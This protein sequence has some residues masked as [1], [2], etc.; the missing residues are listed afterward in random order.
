M[1][2]LF[3]T[4]VCALLCSLSME[5]AGGTPVFKLSGSKG[6]MAISGL[7]DNGLWAVSAAAPINEDVDH[8]VASG[9]SII[10]VS[11]MQ[12]TTVPCANGWGAVS[13]ISDDGN[14]VVGMLDG[15]PAYYTVSTGQWTTLPT[16]SNCDQG[17][18]NSVSADG[19]IAVG[20]GQI[21][22]NEIAAYP[23]IYDLTTNTLINPDNL[24]KYDMNHEK[25]DGHFLHGISG[26]GRYFLGSLS[27]A[28]LQ[29][30]AMC[31]YI[32][33]RQEGTYRWI[34]FKSTGDNNKAKWTPDVDG[35]YF[36]DGGSISCNGQWVGGS[37][38]MVHEQAG[39]EWANEYRCTYR[40]DVANDRI[41]I[42]EAN[43]ETD[44]DGASIT[45]SGNLLSAAP[46]Q[47]PYPTM[48]FR[49]G[50]YYYSMEQLMK[51]A[52]NDDFNNRSGCDVSGRPVAVSGDG[53]V[54]AANCYN[55][56]YLCL[57]DED[58]NDACARVDLLGNYTAEP[59]NNA[60][61]S[62]L[63]TIKLRFDRKIAVAQGHSASEIKL[64]KADGTLIRNA[65]SAAPDESGF[66]LLVNFR[67]T[68]LSKQSPKVSIEIPEGF[69]VLAGDATQASK[70][71]TI[72]YNS[73][74][75]KPVALVSS[76][77][78]DGAS[79]AKLDMQ[80]N[81]VML[82]FDA[83]LSLKENPVA[84]LY[85]EGE[86]QPVCNLNVLASGN[87]LMLY[88]VSAQNLFDGTTYRVVLPAA[89]V[90]DISGYQYTANQNEEVSLTL[91]GNY[92]RQISSDDKY[93]FNEGCDNYDNFMFYEGDVLEPGEVAQGWGFQAQTPWIIVRTSMETN[94]MA[95]AAHSMFAQGGKS[96]DWMSTPQL[97]IP[98]K[99]CYLAFDAQSYLK[100]KADRLKVYVYEENSV[101]NTMS[102][103]FVEAMRATTPV[104]NEQ[105]TPGQSE[106]GLENDWTHYIVDLS[107]YAGK[108]IY[109]AFQ[110]ENENQ[111]AVFLDNIQVVHDIKFLTSITTESRTVCRESIAIKGVITVDTDIETYSSLN[112]VL[113]D[114]AGATV[115]TI[116]KSGLNMKKG[117]SRNFTFPEDLPLTLGADNKFTIEAT[118]D[119]DK[120]TTMGSVKNL[121]FEPVK[122]V[123]LEEY[124][125][126]ECGNCPMGIRAIENLESLYKEQII[127][128]TIRT[129]MSDPLASG[130]SQYS[131][132]LG[133]DGMGAPSATIDRTYASGPMVS[134]GNDYLFSGAGL[135]DDK[136]VEQLVWL[137]YVQRELQEPADAD[138][139]LTANYD[140]AT[141]TIT[142]N[143]N[144]RYALN[145]ENQN[146]GLFTVITESGLESYQSNYFSSVESSTLGEW[147][148][149]G[150]YG[151]SVVYPYVVNDL[152]RG[153]V[154]RT[155]NG[156]YG[157]IP[158]NVVASQD[159]T[160]TITCPLPSTVAVA[161]N[162]DI[163][164]MMID[165][166]TN[167]VINA[168]KVSL[169][170]ASA[171]RDLNKENDTKLMIYDLQGR[172]FNAP[173]KGINII[174]GK[175]VIF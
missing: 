99:L 17:H 98:D 47:M 113:K 25:T 48:M 141:K 134:S 68:E 64:K 150:V 152:A 135:Y 28:Y 166:N 102:E 14:I 127:P 65:G 136:G 61:F 70:A 105:L 126:A 37:A 106:E 146:V 1:K 59:A 71:I 19:K 4:F 107:A 11:D 149:G 154:G 145:A 45:N 73:R 67:A 89:T 169:N 115:S 151:S 101:Y 156:T 49:S 9:G 57:L 40:Y 121:V 15:K 170:A 120:A 60:T 167:R 138:I 51:Y 96:D 108:N 119:N 53:R 56:H 158:A 125:G 139:N 112:L 84:Y 88:P 93:L 161:N 137:D 122:H 159:Y 160:T 81:P 153:I 58:I 142:A 2:K 32:Y 133:L 20:F 162:C 155:F 129:Y 31:T 22:G 18:L 143:V 12:I 76:Y 24:P 118:L 147:G 168:N 85:R 33:D 27:S 82:T 131:Q 83:S 165:G 95:I 123:T 109:I 175:K 13:D 44:M 103:N 62:V 69:I 114:A 157:E 52:Y 8:P 164:V 34:G 77:P 92:V 10:R 42:Y 7:S 36:I 46:A 91:H 116:S 21:S 173:Q 110:N 26:D 5:A 94:D 163:V 16:L 87:Q 104:F 90:A 86:E 38:Y 128:I 50:N 79:V 75:T 144:V 55:R 148:K 35:L 124:T 43:G 66:S 30:V 172:R 74:E 63:Q 29:P 100:T 97:F 111:S 3:F 132:F 78:A 39:S 171:I 80:T 23:A 54:I 130:M 117:D 6:E 41:E 72:N 174:N 140:E